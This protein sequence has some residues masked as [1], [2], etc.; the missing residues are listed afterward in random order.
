MITN[1]YI[2]VLQ[3]IQHG[4]KN[5]TKDYLITKST[6]ITIYFCIAKTF[7]KSAG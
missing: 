2:T 5:K 1:I 3:L 6:T 7:G 4:N